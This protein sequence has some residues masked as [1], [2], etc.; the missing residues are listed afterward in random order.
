LYWP[1][2]DGQPQSPLGPLAAFATAEGY[3]AKPD[4]HTAFHGYYYKML[5]SQGS[6]AK[7]GEK[8]YLANG[9][10]VGGFAAVAYPAEYG[11]SGIMTF[12]VNQD[13]L[14]QKDLGKATPDIASTMNAFDP[15]PGWTPVNQDEVASN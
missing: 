10:M 2:P 15:G 9:K 4:A 12:I 1:S 5:T 8:N 13:G 14:F 3:K 11:N 6:N 7:G